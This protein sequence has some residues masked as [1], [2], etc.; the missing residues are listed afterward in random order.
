MNWAMAHGHLRYRDV[1]DG[2]WQTRFQYRVDA[3]NRVSVEV[4]QIGETEELDEP[5]HYA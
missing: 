5:E 2:E 1:A 3:G 4:T